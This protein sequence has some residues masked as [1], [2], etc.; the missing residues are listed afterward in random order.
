MAQARSLSP[1]LTCLT[2]NNSALRGYSRLRVFITRKVAR[3]L[4]RSFMNERLGF[5]FVALM[6]VPVALLGQEKPLMSPAPP[7]VHSAREPDYRFRAATTYTEPT[8][9][10]SRLVE[11]LRLDDCKAR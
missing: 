2:R 7:A 5:V 10:S 1:G 11:I 9:T 4:E 8:P 6:A 3:F